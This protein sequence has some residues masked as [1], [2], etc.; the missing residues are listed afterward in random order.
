MNTPKD[1]GYNLPFNAHVH[2]Q[3]MKRLESFGVTI[4]F[5]HSGGVVGCGDFAV[6]F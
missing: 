4:V 6:M 1:K 5:L 3:P 2:W